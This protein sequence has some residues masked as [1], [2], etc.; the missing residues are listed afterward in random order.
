MLLNLIAALA[1]AWAAVAVDVIAESALTD[2]PAIRVFGRT[3]AEPAQDTATLILVL[4]GISLGAIVMAGIAARVQ[5]HKAKA[6]GAELQRRTE[7]RSV[8]QA[9]LAAR[10]DLLTWRITELQQQADELLAK[11]D[12]LLDELGRV[13]AK[14]QELRTEAE[15]SKESLARLTEELTVVPELRS[16]PDDPPPDR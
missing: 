11:R 6:F 8:A 10:N 15:R 13:S 9:G 2:G 4:A 3:V 7:E 5:Y 12:K 14:T 16:T 1:A